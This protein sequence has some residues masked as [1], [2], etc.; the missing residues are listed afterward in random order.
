MRKN[1][2]IDTDAYKL[3]HWKQYVKGLTK[4][5][6]YC[7]PRTGGRFPT[8]SY[9][10]LQMLVQDHFLDRVTSEMIDEAEEE[11]YLTF[12]TDKYF[13]RAAWEKVK[14][15]G[16]LPM[17]IRTLPEGME[18]PV[19]NSL[20][21]LESDANHP[22]FATVLNSLETVIM[23]LWY[24]TTISTNSLYILK[25]LK[26]LVELTGTVE[27]LPFM[28]ND[29]GLRGATGLESGGRA[30]VGHLLHFMGSDNMTSSRFI[31][32][33]YGFK[34][35]AKSVWA[36]EHSV[37]TS[38]GPGRGEFDYVNAQLDRA[39]DDAILSLVI[40]S[41]DSINFVKNVIG[42]HEIKTR[43]IN[44]SGRV[45]LRPDSGIPKVMVLTILNLLEEIFGSSMNNKGYKVLN[46]NVGVIQGDGMNRETIIDLYKHIISFGW[47]TD[48]L[49][50][51]SGGGLLQEGFTRDTE[52]FAIK[53]SYGELNGA[54]FNIQKDPKTDPSKK[55]K[56][57]ELK[58]ISIDDSY[59][60]VKK[61]EPGEDL[62]RVLY[63]NGDF[64]PD[65]FENILKRAAI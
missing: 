61:E 11:S 40:D 32:D 35:R 26:P 5:Y 64:Y 34:G 57:G 48:N 19:S 29:F 8:V 20:F 33:Y 6:S 42:S 30:G 12:G 62:M 25:E 58:V 14:N 27:L 59:K 45:V 16:Y 36:T 21:T 24:P 2:I 50:V 1:I 63:K 60:T 28:V 15:L 39:P 54:P 13:N 41:Y 10:G 38:Y 4:L 55:S 23:P 31:K 53:A 22:W 37:A 56:T 44:R 65:K 17:T 46:H 3:T 9:I 52:R 43:I 49:V 7:E 18:V 51:G 47:S